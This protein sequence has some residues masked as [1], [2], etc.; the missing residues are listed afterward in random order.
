MFIEAN[1]ERLINQNKLNEMYK[2]QNI[3]MKR[4]QRNELAQM[5]VYQLEEYKKQKFMLNNQRWYE[6]MV[7]V[8]NVKDL[9][10]FK[11]GLMMADISLQEDRFK[12]WK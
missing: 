10:E 4:D 8:H 11:R 1:R 7:Q 3:A 6:K 9:A 5:Q 2:A 12:L